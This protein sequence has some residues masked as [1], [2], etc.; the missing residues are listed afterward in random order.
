MDSYRCHP[1][2]DKGQVQPLQ[3]VEG[4]LGG[5]KGLASHPRAEPAL[6]HCYGLDLKVSQELMCRAT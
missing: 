2:E 5:E 6:H 4:V 3:Q 1:G